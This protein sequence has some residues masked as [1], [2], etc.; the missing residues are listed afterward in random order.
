MLLFMMIMA[1]LFFFA[2]AIGKNLK[3]FWESGHFV[4]DGVWFVEECHVYIFLNYEFESDCMSQSVNAV[5][6]TVRT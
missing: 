1:N 6:L 2:F 4:S 3:I 5:G